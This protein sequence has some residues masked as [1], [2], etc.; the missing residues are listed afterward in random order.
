MARKTTTTHTQTSRS[1]TGKTVATKRIKS[2]E[3]K[4]GKA[5]TSLEEAVVRMHHGVSVK[6][7]AKLPTNAV[8]DEVMS[9]LFEIEVRAHV[10]TGRIDELPDVPKKTARTNAKTQKVVDKLKGKK[11]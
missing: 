3:P 10:E 1:T 2:L 8:N 4:A 11:R 9:Q 5:L 6:P 7:S